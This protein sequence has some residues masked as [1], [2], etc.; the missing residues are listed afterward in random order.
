MDENVLNYFKIWKDYTIF[1]YEIINNL[2]NEICN[3]ILFN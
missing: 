2:I 1:K 3:E